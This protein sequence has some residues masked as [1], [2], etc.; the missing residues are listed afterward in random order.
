MRPKIVLW[1]RGQG[2]T[3]SKYRQANQEFE[4]L[5]REMSERDPNALRRLMNTWR[6]ED[7]HHLQQHHRQYGWDRIGLSEPVMPPQDE[8]RQ[9]VVTVLLK[10]RAEELRRAIQ[11][12]KQSY[13]NV[14]KQYEEAKREVGPDG[15]WDTMR[16]WARDEDRILYNAEH[17]GRDLG[18]ARRIMEER[19]AQLKRAA[20]V[21]IRLSKLQLGKRKRGEGF[22][23]RHALV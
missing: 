7:T 22:F 13:N 18:E 15:L 10:D 3:S 20:L 6:P 2:L 5:Y 19:I 11:N 1:K 4:N 23:V 16:R 14:R 8:A 17:N 12:E 9:N 21:E